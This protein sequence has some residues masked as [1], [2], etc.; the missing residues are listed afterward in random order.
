M[1]SRSILSVGLA[2]VLLA[3][4]AGGGGVG[5]L[6]S[7][8]AIEDAPL[9]S[10]MT[11]AHAPVPLNPSYRVT[12]VEV[13]VPQTLTTSEDNGI[14]PSVDLL[15]QEDPAGDR[16]AQVDDLLTKALEQGVAGLNGSRA[17]KLEVVV[18]RFHAL[19]KRTRYTYGGEHEVWMVMAVR[20]AATGELL[21]PGR[22]IGFDIRV[23]ADEALANEAKGI[24]QRDEITAAVGQMIR[25][26]LTR[27]RDFLQ[28]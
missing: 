28:G 17:V 21:E 22:L 26:E 6:V 19:T 2:A 14:K 5:G 25:N 7:R 13:T 24:Y 1:K 27:P 10:S 4:C 20:D 18:T 16:H 15:W 3:G 23:S 8:N 12:G 9:F 11:G